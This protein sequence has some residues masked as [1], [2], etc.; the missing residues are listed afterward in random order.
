MKKMSLSIML[1]MAGAIVGSDD[2]MQQARTII[3][4]GGAVD[5]DGN[6]LSGDAAI[7]NIATKLK[8]ANAWEKPQN[9]TRAENFA[10][11]LAKH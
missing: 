6:V 2:F 3:A 8:E 5:R 1:L 11:Y 9:W 7:T 4:R 10:D